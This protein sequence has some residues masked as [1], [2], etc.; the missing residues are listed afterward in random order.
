MTEPIFAAVE[1]DIERGWDAFREHLPRHRYHDP[2]ATPAPAT[3]APATEDPAMSLATIVQA[4]E[5]DAQALD[6]LVQGFL[7][8]HLPQLH[9]LADSVEHSAL[10]QAVLP[11][12]GV[13]DP[14]VEAGAVTILNALAS[15]M[16]APA[17]A[18]AD[19]QQPEP[20]PAA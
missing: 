7:T 11:L 15:T 14:A 18:V 4:A 17:A 8:Q 9:Q 5:K 3:P 19:V 16:P 2:D 6:G 10:F 13:L 1:H 20:A 12:V